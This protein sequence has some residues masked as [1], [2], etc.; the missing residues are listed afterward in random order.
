MKFRYETDRL[1]LK[2]L[3][4]TEADSVLRF[5]LDNKELFERSEPERQEQFYTREHQRAILTA[6]YN[7]A[8]QGTLCR[9][10]LFRKEAPAEI[11]GTISLRDIQ[12]HYRQSCL[13][14]YKL[15]ERYFHQGYATEAIRE[16]VRIAFDELLL[17]RI[18]AEV[19]P[20]NEAS[21][22]LMERLGF[23]NEGI[24]R[25][26]FFLNGKWTDHIR[27]SLISSHPVIPERD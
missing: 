23:V 27:Y 16:T 7:M 4:P 1:I 10:W 22:R 5:Y 9:F 12:R 21:I 3:E 6:E 8:V 13:L 11:I 25:K 15:D 26:I 19:M 18:T 14:G 20:D 2:I 17:H 24:E